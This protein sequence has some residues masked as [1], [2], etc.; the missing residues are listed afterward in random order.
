MI[1]KITIF[2]MIGLFAISLFAQNDNFSAPIKWQRYKVSGMNASLLLPKLPVLTTRDSV[3]ARQKKD[4]Y[5]VYA[6]DVAYGFNVYSKSKSLIP[7]TCPDGI[8][9]GVKSFEERIKELKVITQNNEG[10]TV[11]INK[12]KVIYLRGQPI[13]YW[14]FDD[15]ENDKWVELWV[16]NSDESNPKVRKFLTSLEL[17]KKPKGIE[18]GE[19]ADRVLGDAYPE[20]NAVEKTKID[21]KKSAD[22]DES[23]P[24]RFI[25]KPSPNYT[26]IAAKNNVSGSVI[27]RVTLLANGG[28]GDVELTPEVLPFG[29]TEQAVI[30]AKKIVFLPARKNGVP[31]AVTKKIQFSFI[32]Y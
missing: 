32:I 16:A 6:E 14:I 28:I 12:K 11:L 9:F 13:S 27:L 25:T 30:A 23:M 31:Y 29:L 26:E 17:V 19:G 15:L 21:Q 4:N 7:N 10:E 18:I 24:V 22:N 8:I 20:N 2:L 5:A 1:K 3:C